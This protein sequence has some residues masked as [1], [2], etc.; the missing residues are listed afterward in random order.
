LSSQCMFDCDV[1]VLVC[2]CLL[3]GCWEQ[4]WEV[5]SWA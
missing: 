1:V 2:N 5:A 3:V 4:W